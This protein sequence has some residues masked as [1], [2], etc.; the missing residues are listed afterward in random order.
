MGGLCES[1]NNAHASTQTNSSYQHPHSVTNILNTPSNFNKGISYIECTYDIKDIN[2]ETQ[3]MNNRGEVFINE[4]IESKIKILNSNQREKLTLKKKFNR[5]G[6]NIVIFIIE[7]KLNNM[8]YMFDK[9]NS[10]KEIKFHFVE[11]VQVNRM[12]SLF[13]NCNE[14]EYLDLTSFNTSNVTDM[15]GMFSFCHKLKEIKGINN[16]NTI[17]A[18]S[19][20]QMFCDCKELEYLDLTSF[21]TSNVTDMSLMFCGCCKLKQITGINNFNT[22]YVNN[23]SGMF[24]EWKGINIFRFI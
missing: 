14:L 19:M 5:I 13:E 7:E 18:T 22:N 21:N 20:N 3:I 15:S 12:R 1:S 10:L 2:T 23:M 4:E 16:F 9:C 8:S 24:Q 17:N 11:T 6:R